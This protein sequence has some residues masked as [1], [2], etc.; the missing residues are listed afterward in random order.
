MKKL[1]LCMIVKNESHIIKE[2]LE[3]V[4][5]YIDYWV[6]ADNGSTDGTQQLI[7]DFFEEK[8]IPGELH[9]VEWV[10]F[11][12][13]RTEALNLC[14]GKAEYCL[15]IDADDTIQGKM[16]I[17]KEMKMDGYALRIQR[18]DFTWWRTQ[19]FKT[20]V[21]WRYTGVL[22]EYAECPRG[23]GEPQMTME[24][25]QGQ[26]FVDARTLGARNK[27]EDGTGIDP[28]QK[29]SR[30]ADILAKALEDDPD[31][32][33]Y[34]FYLAQSYFDSQQW[35]KSLEAYSKRAAMGGWAEEVF[36]SVFRCAMIKLIRGD[37]WPESQD[38][39]MQAWNVRPHRAEPL[40]N[41]AKIHRTNGNPHL[42][43]LFAQQAMKIP[44]PQHDILFISDDIYK[45]QILD[46]Y[47]STAFYM[48]DL[49]GG[50]QAAQKLVNMCNKNEI[51][52]EHHSRLRDNL[53]HYANALG[54]KAK[55][56]VEINK[57]ALENKKKNQAK[58]DSMKNKRKKRDKKKARN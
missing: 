46:E 32:A 7:K 51:P 43:Y 49:E 18:G 6:I 27:N 33:R 31:N 10:D 47:A 12:H 24:R 25:I 1:S 29:Y 28:I 3:S 34:Q 45:W 22:H 42:A 17:P 9:E 8:G 4:Y 30:D 21:G 11:G 41:L 53:G 48:N 44:Y 52:K 19:I 26:Y 38:T 13:N 54:E 23:E 14:D 37:E 56:Q 2:C 40:Y 20:G 36:Y 39:L 16:R 50:Y 35:D 15:M 5:P 57:Q 58:L 55:L